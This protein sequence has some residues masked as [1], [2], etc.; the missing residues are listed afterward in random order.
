MGQTGAAQFVQ[1][2]NAGI[3][4]QAQGTIGEADYGVRVPLFDIEVTAEK[5]SPYSKMSQNELALQFY[6]AGFFNPQL[7]DQAL[8]CLDMM[9]FPRK[10]SIM[11]KI[12]QNGTLYQ[13]LMMLQ[14]QALALGQMVDASRGG[15]EVTASLAQ[16]FGMAAPGFIAGEQTDAAK[17]KA[18]G[19][20]SKEEAATTRNA[21]KRVSE[22]TD[23]T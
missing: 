21:R 22:A 18:L 9:D 19:G 3:Q 6:Q 15:N 2:S 20:D 16:Q 4:P 8:A 14:Q 12:A 7:S 17:S 5:Q 1:Y 11:Q 10:E 13:Q 23:P